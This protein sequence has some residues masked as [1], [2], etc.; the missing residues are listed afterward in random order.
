[1]VFPRQA[2]SGRF[3]DTPA[4]ERQIQVVC[5][6]QAISR[7]H[8]S[9]RDFQSLPNDV[10]QP[11]LIESAYSSWPTLL[12]VHVGAKPS[13]VRCGSKTVLAAP[14]R[15]F[16]SS[17]NNEHHPSAPACR[18]SANKRLMH[19]SN[20]AAYSITSSAWARSD[21]GMVR[22]SEFAV[23]RLMAASNAVI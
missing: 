11:A 10:R 7:H 9:H 4:H 18:K 22:P 2:A 17:P 23:L 15:H 5:R 16:Q 19:R 8:M 21:V 14:N 13:D 1:M 3:G 6:H 20:S 12:A